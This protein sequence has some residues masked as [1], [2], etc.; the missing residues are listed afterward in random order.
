[1][2]IE[3]SLDLITGSGLL[4]FE[5]GPKREVKLYQGESDF[6]GDQICAIEHVIFYVAGS[7]LA[8]CTHRA[9]RIP[10]DLAENMRVCLHFVE[11]PLWCQAAADCFF[12]CLSDVSV[13]QS[14]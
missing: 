3:L 11:R 9:M 6:L 10:H 5:A 7:L 2:R 4:A 12:W 1:M 13:S 8:F 14:E